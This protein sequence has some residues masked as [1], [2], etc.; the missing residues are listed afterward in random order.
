MHVITR[1]KQIDVSKIGSRQRFKLLNFIFLDTK[2]DEYPIWMALIFF[3][4]FENKNNITNNFPP[5][6]SCRTSLTS[7][8]SLV[9][10]P[11]L[12]HW[13]TAMYLN[14]KFELYKKLLLI[15]KN[16][17]ASDNFYWI[18]KKFV[19]ISHGSVLSQK[20]LSWNTRNFT[21]IMIFLRNSE[22]PIYK[23][24]IIIYISVS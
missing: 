6:T 4:F 18:Y 19:R 5:H 8:T 21:W 23:N 7:L 13:A 2:N 24:T 12:C 16:D 15:M 20:I 14:V 1:N 9:V 22:T 10:N 3:I 17:Y 11:P